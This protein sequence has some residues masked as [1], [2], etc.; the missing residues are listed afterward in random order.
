[1]SAELGSP[2]MPADEEQAEGI[3]LTR[4]HDHFSAAC[5]SYTFGFPHLEAMR[6]S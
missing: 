5:G 3:T 2:F 4:V 6:R 1:V